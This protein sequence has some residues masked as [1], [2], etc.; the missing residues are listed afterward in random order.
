MATS[1]GTSFLPLPRELRNQIYELYFDDLNEVTI[2]ISHDGS[3]LPPPLA[4]ASQQIRT[5]VLLYWPSKSHDLDSTGHVK[6][7]VQDLDFVPLV[8]CFDRAAGGIKRIFMFDSVDITLS[9]NKSCGGK[10]YCGDR[11]GKIRLQK[12]PDWSDEDGKPVAAQGA[13]YDCDVHWR[14]FGGVELPVR[15]SET[16][17]DQLRRMREAVRGTCGKRPMSR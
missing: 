17:G 15:R 13:S 4:R 6:A 7:R 9:S 2:P 16:S 8:A 14:N 1:P 11:S 3:F 5:E 12:W 10:D